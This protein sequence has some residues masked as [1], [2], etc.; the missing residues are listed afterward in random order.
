MAIVATHRASSP[1]WDAKGY[2]IEVYQ[3]HIW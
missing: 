1:D 2:Q 3:F